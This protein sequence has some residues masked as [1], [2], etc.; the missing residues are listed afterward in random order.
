MR[1]LSWILLLFFLSVSWCWS[2]KTTLEENET[3]TAV[4]VGLKEYIAQ[5]LKE[6][7]IGVENIQ[8]ESI[9]SERISEAQVRVHFHYSFIHR[10][11]EQE[12]KIDLKGNSLLSPTKNTGNIEEW[13]LEDIQI[14]QESLEYLQQLDVMKV[15]DEQ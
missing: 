6:N 13:G 7:L 1:S 15:T 2:S 10:L 14:E 8:F 11:N 9:W 3:Q 5:Y 12:T 4:Q